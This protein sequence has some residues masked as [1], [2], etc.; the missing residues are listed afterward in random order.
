IREQQHRPDDE[1]D[2]VDLEVLGEGEEAGGKLVRCYR[3]HDD[4]AKVKRREEGGGGETE[5]DEVDDP[6]DES[7]F[8]LQHSIVTAATNLFCGARTTI[9]AI[10]AKR[11]VRQIEEQPLI[12]VGD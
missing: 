12:V 5:V 3:R 9:R 11:L 4:V 7:R 8:L 6:R 2:R 1:D 10:G